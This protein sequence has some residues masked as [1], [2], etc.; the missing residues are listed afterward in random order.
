[1]SA[2]YRGGRRPTG[3]VGADRGAGGSAE[4]GG[5][6][7]NRAFMRPTLLPAMWE[8]RVWVEDGGLMSYGA[9]PRELYRRA[10]T[11]AD[12]ILRGA[13]PGDLPVQ[14]AT[15]FELVINRASRGS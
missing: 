5:S 2:L 12:R 3:L 4:N 11:Y 7:N 13:K 10:A 1:M 9:N 15:K 14:Q 6:V 8:W